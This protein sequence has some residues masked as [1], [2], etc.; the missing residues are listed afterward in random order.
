MPITTD[1]KFP[2]GLPST[3]GFPP[4]N[5]H[6]GYQLASSACIRLLFRTPH[7][8]HE[9]SHPQARHSS[10]CPVSQWAQRDV[11][12]G[13]SNKLDSREHPSW[14]RVPQLPMVSFKGP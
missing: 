12:E 14:S 9:G 7:T 13:L 4:L 6:T 11:V 5:A 1:C 8:R 2:A 10:G 3:E